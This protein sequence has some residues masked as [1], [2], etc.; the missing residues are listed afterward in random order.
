MEKFDIGDTVEYEFL[1][2]KRKGFVQPSFGKHFP[3]LLK[4]QH[5]GDI[6]LRVDECAVFGVGK[7]FLTRMVL[8]EKAKW[9]DLK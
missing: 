8:T 4:V 1:N 2:T 3:F 9:N 7:A 5:T 6:L